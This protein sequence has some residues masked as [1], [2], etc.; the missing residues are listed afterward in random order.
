MRPSHVVI[1]HLRGFSVGAFFL[2]R[3]R[4]QRGKS[5]AGGALPGHRAGYWPPRRLKPAPGGKSCSKP[6]SP[7]TAPPPHCGC[8]IAESAPLVQ[9]R[10]SRRQRPDNRAQ[11][12][13]AARP[14]R[15]ARCRQHCRQ[16]HRQ[17]RRNRRPP[18]QIMPVSAEIAIA[19]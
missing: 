15:K 7:Y 9:G 11:V 5:A 8:S 18:P 4:R 1:R 2:S 12:L 10:G 13:R 14:D 3:P 16:R 19:A 6:Q 17:V